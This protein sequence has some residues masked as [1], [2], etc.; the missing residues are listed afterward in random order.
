MHRSSCFRG[1]EETPPGA[2]RAAPRETWSG[3]SGAA[4]A[5]LALVA[6]WQLCV[7]ISLPLGLFWPSA[8][9][10]G[11]SY[12]TGAHLGQGAVPWGPPGRS[13]L[14]P[15]SRC[16]CELLLVLTVTLWR[17]R[18]TQSASPEWGASFGPIERM[19]HGL[20]NSLQGPGDGK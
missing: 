14:T 19:L 7:H 11:S 10:A 13:F 6:G 16:A 12:L 15:S 9:A 20:T 8:P 1:N 5:V 18:P 3:S 17:G 2:P 4:P